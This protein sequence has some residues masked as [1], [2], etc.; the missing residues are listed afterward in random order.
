MNYKDRR[1]QEFREKYAHHFTERN[2]DSVWREDEMYTDLAQ[3]L[4]ESIEQAQRE[5][6]IKIMGL[7]YWSIEDLYGKEIADL[8]SKGVN[9]NYEELKDNR[10]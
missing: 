4:S 9:E 7:F 8:I 10:K 2:E 6:R 1:T 5:E 3:F